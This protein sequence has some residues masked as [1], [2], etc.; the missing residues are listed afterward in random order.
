[1]EEEEE[2]KGEKW[3]TEEKRKEEVRRPLVACL[4]ASDSSLCAAL[5]RDDHVQQLAGRRRSQVVSG[6]DEAGPRLET[7]LF[8]A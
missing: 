2:G 1:M 7:V 4:E 6:G 3:R 5:R 8:T